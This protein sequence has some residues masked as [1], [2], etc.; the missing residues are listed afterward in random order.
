MLGKGKAAVVWP[1]NLLKDET[2]KLFRE[3]QETKSRIMEKRSGGLTEGKEKLSEAD[4]K[5]SSA[6]DQKDHDHREYFRHLIEKSNERS[7]LGT[8]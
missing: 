2:L 5:R 8:S 4:G 3:A 1:F 6:I 7:G